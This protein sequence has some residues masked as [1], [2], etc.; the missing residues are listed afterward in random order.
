[1]T[2]FNKLIKQEQDKFGLTITTF[3][4]ICN[5]TYHVMWTWLNT[6]KHPTATQ[7]IHLINALCD[8]NKT[9]F[10]HNMRKVMFAIRDDVDG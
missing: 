9:T 4:K 5:V 10:A 8:L 1:M 3:S 6:D 7:M 2:N